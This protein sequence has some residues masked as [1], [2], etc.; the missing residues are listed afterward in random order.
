M[1]RWTLRALDV[2][3]DP[4]LEG[5]VL[6]WDPTPLAQPHMPVSEQGFAVSG[7]VSH[8]HNS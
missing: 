8:T 6:Y 1:L 3:N 7:I 5:C 2:E 4:G